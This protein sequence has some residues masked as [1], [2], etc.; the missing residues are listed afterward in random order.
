[1]KQETSKYLILSLC[2]L[3][4]LVLT[5]T[6]PAQ[7]LDPR[8]YARVP[9]D[10]TFAVAGFSYSDGAIVTVE[11]SPIQGLNAKV[12][13]PSLGVGH[14][15]SLFGQTAQAFAVIPYSWAQLSGLVV[16]QA[17][18]TSRSGLSDMRLRFSVLF[19]GAPAATGAEFAK[20]PTQTILGASLTVTAPI[21]Q[22]YPE[23]VI[24]LGANRWAFKPEIAVSQP[25]GDQWL[26]DLYAAVWLFTANDSYYPGNAN[27]TQDPLTTFQAHVSYTLMRQMW[28]AIDVTHYVG[29]LSYV[30]GSSMDDRQNNSRIGGT[31]VLPVGD[32]HSVKI[33]GSTGAIIRIGARL[34]HAG[35][36]MADDS[37]IDEIR[38]ER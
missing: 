38:C 21:G 12:E 27:R 2:G 13:T 3:C 22:Y 34:H 5:A 36:G 8:A 16:G 9:V 7:D 26:F 23:K 19:L 25:L 33:S 35:R 11:T 37:L 24:N 18:T 30:N 10:M 15:F 20:V 29:G 17:A 31:L 1:M 28:V 4:L 6:A 32:R 14:T